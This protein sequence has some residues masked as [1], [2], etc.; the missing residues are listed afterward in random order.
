MATGEEVVAE[1][2]DATTG[3]S[4]TVDA[5]TKTLLRQ[6]FCF[7]IHIVRIRAYNRAIL[8]A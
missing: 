3:N 7:A 6:G 5:F 4:V 1:A 8:D 2:D